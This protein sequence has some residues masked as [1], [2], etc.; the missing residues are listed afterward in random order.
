MTYTLRP[1]DEQVMV[2]TGASSGIGLVTAR[3]AARRGAR[4]VL[5]AR[6]DCDLGEIVDGIRREGGRAIAVAADVADPDHVARI[7]SEAVEAFG[8]IDS[9]VNNAAVS[10]YGRLTEVPIADMRRQMDINYWGQVYGSLTA[11]RHM[12]GRGGALINVGSAL[13][14]R[15]IP[16]QGNYCAA[17]HALKAFTDTL[18]ME[19]EES[20]IP[21]SVTLVK[22]AS[23]D[24]PFFDKARTYLGT[25][26]QPVPP[27]YAPEVVS[28][29][30]LAAAERPIRELVA[31]GAGAKLSFARFVPRLADLYMER[32]TFAAQSTGEPVADRGDNLEAP[33]RHDGGERGRNW[34]GHTRETSLYTSAMLRPARAAAALGGLL[35]AAAVVQQI[36]ARTAATTRSQRGR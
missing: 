13:S 3:Q 19:L 31:G 17:K 24:T 11:V 6:N 28:G 25:E 14:D 2:V 26:P 8:H 36:R 4:V 12:T 34:Q 1:I 7:A 18:R 21:I 35:A 27:V 9:W 15:A 22:P 30:I 16:L 5:A 23:V 10:M 29:V 20:G 32:R 33:L